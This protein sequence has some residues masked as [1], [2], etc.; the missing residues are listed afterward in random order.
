MMK[1]G[2][3]ETLAAAVADSDADPHARRILA[4]DLADALTTTSE[5]FDPTRWLLQCDIGEVDPSDVAQ[6]TKRLQLRVE[7]VVRKRRAYEERTGDKLE[8]Y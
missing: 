1:R 8:R 5:R 7:S 6:W 3:Y 4:F 2:E